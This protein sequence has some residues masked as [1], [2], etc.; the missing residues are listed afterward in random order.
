MQ[1]PSSFVTK[2][3]KIARSVKRDY[4]MEDG[5]KPDTYVA[6]RFKKAGVVL[7]RPPVY[8]GDG[9]SGPIKEIQFVVLYN[10]K[11]FTLHF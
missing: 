3:R 1:L 2:C 10:N 11:E 9:V 4:K 7:C 6:E 5:R 8:G